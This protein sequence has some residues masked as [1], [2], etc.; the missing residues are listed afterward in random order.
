MNWNIDARPVILIGLG[1][2]ALIGFAACAYYGWIYAREHVYNGISLVI[3]Y[4]G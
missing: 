3:S 1:I 4:Y 2:L